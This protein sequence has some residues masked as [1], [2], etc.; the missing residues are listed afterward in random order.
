VEAL[1]RYGDDCEEKVQDVLNQKIED[2]N[3]NPMKWLEPLVVRLAGETQLNSAVPLLVTKLSQDGGDLTNEECG[4]ALSKIGTSAVLRA[5][6]EAYATSPRYFRL[7]ATNPLENI[8]SDLAVETCLNL[9]RQ[10]QD[11]NVRG[12]LAHALLSQF[13]VEGVEVSTTTASCRNTWQ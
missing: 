12:D 4:R 5:V 13:S 6:A 7:Y 8:H 11:A 10:E 3:D 1:A 9:I 2:Y